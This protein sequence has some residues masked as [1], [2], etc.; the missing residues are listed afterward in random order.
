LHN[1]WVVLGLLTGYW[2]KGCLK[3]H[4]TFTTEETNFLFLSY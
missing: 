2:E 4:F 3:E 1:H